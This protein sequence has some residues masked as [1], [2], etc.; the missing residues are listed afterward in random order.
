VV[1]IKLVAAQSLPK[2]SSANT[3]KPSRQDF[4]EGWGIPALYEDLKIVIVGAYS[5]II[6]ILEILGGAH[7][8]SRFYRFD[9]AFVRLIGVAFVITGAGFWLDKKWALIPLVLTY[10]ISIAEVA[11][12]ARARYWLPLLGGTFLFLGLPLIYLIAFYTSER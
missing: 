4:G 11:I 8:E 3:P 6:G 2:T 5:C 10:I 9:D 7:E 1:P 12:T